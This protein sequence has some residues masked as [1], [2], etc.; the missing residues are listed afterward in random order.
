MFFIFLV[1]EFTYDFAMAM[2]DFL[3]MQFGWYPTF[4]QNKYGKEE[5]KESV[6]KKHRR[7]TF[8]PHRGI[9]C[10]NFPKIFLII[11]CADIAARENNR[12]PH[13]ED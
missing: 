10:R 1:S 7:Q 9:A 6:D 12:K 5:V 8:H 4:I 3:A 13:N 2:E 11:L